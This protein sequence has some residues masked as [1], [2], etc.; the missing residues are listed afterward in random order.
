MS[1]QNNTNTEAEKAEAERIEQERIQ[2]EEA[3]NQEKAA[4]AAAAL[5]AQSD[6]Q[7]LA[8]SDIE[9]D[10]GEAVK[11]SSLQNN[12]GVFDAQKAAT[13]DRERDGKLTRAGMEAAIRDG[14]SVQLSDGRTITKVDD[15][16]TGA[17]LAKG[18]ATEEARVR[19]E[20]EAQKAA[21]D[22]QLD[23]LK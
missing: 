16:P 23:S 15:L 4:A 12:D 19:A 9:A 2:A 11:N 5:Q 7:A 10:Q 20:L 1:G 22:A 18:D 17:A 13:A 8:A 21:I 6:A 14:G 3:A